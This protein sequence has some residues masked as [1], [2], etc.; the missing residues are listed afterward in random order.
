MVS[1][2]SVYV[3]VCISA[4]TLTR[5]KSLDK[6]NTIIKIYSDVH[7]G[8]TPKSL[9]CSTDRTLVPIRKPVKQRLAHT[10]ARAFGL[11][12]LE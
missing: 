9:V 4:C 12:Q 8:L 2:T 6:L 10:H 7:V 1:S 3:C 5:L 11:S